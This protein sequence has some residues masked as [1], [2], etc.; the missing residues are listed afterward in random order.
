MI[1]IVWRRGLLW[2]AALFLCALLLGGGGPHAPLLLAT[3]EVVGLC[4]LLRT[5][6]TAQRIEPRP[7]MLAAI[8]IVI[9]MLL[10]PVL[11]I[12]P[13]PLRWACDLAGRDLYCS[14]VALAA[15]PGTTT[16]W[17]LSP[18]DTRRAALALLPPVAMF[19]ATMGLDR[20]ARRMLVQIAIGVGVLS[21]LT[22]AAQ[23]M[24][25]DGR[26]FPYGLPPY[27][28]APGL[29]ANYNHQAFFLSAILLLVVA[30]WIEDARSA[31]A[32]IRIGI[33]ILLTIGVIITSSRAGFGL[34]VLAILAGGS[35]WLRQLRR[36]R[37]GRLRGRGPLIGIVIAILGVCLLIGLLAMGSYRSELMADRIAQAASDTRFTFWGNTRY[38]IGLY[39]P[40]GSGFGT[41]DTVYQSVEPLGELHS[42]YVNH[43]H[44]DYLEIVLEGGLIAAAL[45]G[46]FLIWLTVRLVAIWRSGSTLML[47]A[48]GVILL[49][50]LH[51]IV[52]YPLRTVTGATLFA[53]CCGLLISPGVATSHIEHRTDD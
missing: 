10:L 43:A 50:L 13:I 38:A 27:D 34:L 28:R 39:F 53:F 12:L 25:G 47:A 3:T 24:A 20:T 31:I 35:L 41:F 19:V 29:F 8:G 30:D 11:Q 52:D 40:A 26:F 32:P 2:P 46:A 33:L 9:A 23:I 42:Y 37:G 36:T 17:S 18:D 49:A 51:S 21:A 1:D 22:G 7:A 16:T 6:V 44:N 14:T 5:A 15:V 48:A 45:I 4:V